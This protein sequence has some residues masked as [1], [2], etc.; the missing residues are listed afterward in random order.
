MMFFGHRKPFPY[1]YRLQ[2]LQLMCVTVWAVKPYIS[3][4]VCRA[5]PAP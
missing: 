3:C 5:I 4:W 1:I 2:P